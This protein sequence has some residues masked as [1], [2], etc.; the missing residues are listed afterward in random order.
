VCVLIIAFALGT[1]ATP[2]A[3]G[4][5]AGKLPRI[6]YLT[7]RPEAMQS[8]VEAFRQGLRELGYV[9]GQ[10]IAIEYRSAEIK[11]DRLPDLAAELVRLKVDIIVAAATPAILA[12]KNATS[13]IPIVMAPAADPVGTGLITS[14]ARPGGNITGVSVMMPELAGK[15]LQLLREVLPRVT[16]VAFLALRD[17]SGRRLV[18]ETQVAGQTLGARIQPVIVGG[19]EELDGAFAAILKER[20]G[21]LIVQPALVSWYARRIVDFA[22]RHRMPTISDIRELP[23]A[24]GLMSYGPNVRESNRRAAT[25]VDKILKGAKPG[26]LA[27]EQ[28]TKFEFVVNLKTAKALGLTIPPSLLLQ[29]DRVID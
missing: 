1:L 13:T 9:E 11:L 28:P 6:G 16:R 26:D 25:Y 24:G 19:A 29:A 8:Y 15:R 4:A 21:A 22:A 18:E 7:T 5:Q 23:D 10:N 20:A 2:L 3:A 12:A 17:S 14:L 27:I